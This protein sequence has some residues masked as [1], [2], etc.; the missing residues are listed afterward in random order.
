MTTKLAALVLGLLLASTAQA[1]ISF[2][3]VED[4]IISVGSE[5]WPC[6]IP[7]GGAPDGNVLVIVMVQNSSAQADNPTNGLQILEDVVAASDSFDTNI[8]VGYIVASGLSA[9]ATITFTN[10]F[11]ASETG[12]CVVLEYTGVDTENPI[13][14]HEGAEGAG[15]TAVSGPS[16]DTTG[17]N[18]AMIIQAVGADN[19]GAVSGTPDD[20]PAANERYDLVNGVTSY[21]YVQD[22]LQPTGGPIALD[23]TGLAS[24]SYV[25]VQLAL[26]PAATSSSG[27]LLRRRRD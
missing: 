9:T 17:V 22:Y 7:G 14:A 13:V 20:S 23:V 19:N 16:I 5:D 25:S 18:G 1:A 11:D 12:Q 3:G 24:D 15:L 8:V 4:S 2:V 26:R 6:D 27:L 10:L 21:V